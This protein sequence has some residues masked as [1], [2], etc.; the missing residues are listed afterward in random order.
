MIYQNSPSRRWMLIVFILLMGKLHAQKVQFFNKRDFGHY[1]YSD[2]Y[3]PNLRV[4]LGMGANNREY[5]IDKS[6]TSSY[7]LLNET[8]VGGEI[9]LMYLRNKS[10][11]FYFSMSIPI[12]FSVLF[13]FTESK[14]APII[15]TDYRFALLELNM[16]RKFQG[17]HIKNISVKFIPFFHESTHIGDELTI[18][19]QNNDFDIIR[20]NLSYESA[21]LSVMINDPCN[22]VERNHSFNVGCN[23]LLFG[24]NGWYSISEEEANLEGSLFN[25]GVSFG[26][27]LS[28]RWFEGFL[29]YQYQNPDSKLALKNSMFI[30]SIDNSLRVG[31]D[32]SKTTD[33]EKILYF[34]ENNVYCVNTL[35][36][37]SFLNSQHQKSGVSLFLRAYH[38]LNYHGQFRNIHNYSFYGVSIQYSL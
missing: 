27:V 34:Q 21:K 36:G 15:N 16:L 19:R 10:Q 2:H 35:C 12:S 37:W 23:M 3:A 6:R 32:Y 5:N 13:D 9:P 38:G 29:Q 17:Q 28:T 30:F 18:Y 11:N 4:N 33:Q 31:Y 24:K 7:L 25:K 20:T 26:R 22:K 8:V 1:L 14:T